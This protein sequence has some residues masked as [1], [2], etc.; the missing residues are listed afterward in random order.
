MHDRKENS[1]VYKEATT[2][3]L[4]NIESKIEKI[5]IITLE[6]VKKPISYDAAKNNIIIIDRGDLKEIIKK[7]SYFMEFLKV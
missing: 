3:L 7:P 1:A 5:F 2:K 6:N 4:R